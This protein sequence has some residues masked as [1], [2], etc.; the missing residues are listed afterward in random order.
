MMSV[1]EHIGSIVELYFQPSN[2]FFSLDGTVKIGDFGLATEECRTDGAS[3]TP[4]N[5]A[6]THKPHTNQV[7]T[8]LYMSPEQ[9]NITITCKLYHYHENQDQ[10]ASYG[11]QVVKN[12]LFCIML[13]NSLSCTTVS[14]PPNPKIS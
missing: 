4:M 1:I 13:L 12:K 3:M 6:H 5:A 10:I 9:V 14:C 7:G 11:S 8:K 2:I